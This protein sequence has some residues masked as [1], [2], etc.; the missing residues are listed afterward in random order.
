KAAE[1][2]DDPN[3]QAEEARLLELRTGGR[4]KGA[5]S[6]FPGSVHMDTG[7][8][9]RWEVDGEPAKVDGDELLRRCRLLAACCLFARYWPPEKSGHH[10][11]AR[12]VGGFL[13]RSGVE[14]A[15]VEATVRGIVAAM[16]TDRRQELTRTA[17][18]AATQFKNGGHTYGF[19]ELAKTFGEG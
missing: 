8:E 10:D 9:I 13:A 3:R 6:V 12:V 18:D 19:P 14:P 2:F 11:T 7:E 15:I 5:Q 16:S 1:A 17:K 4:G